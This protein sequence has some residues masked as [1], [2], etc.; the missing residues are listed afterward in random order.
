MADGDVRTFHY[1]RGIAPMMWMLVLISGIELLV[2]HF[3]VSFWSGTAALIL[4]ALTAAIIVWIVLLIRSM[5]RLPVWI[6]EGR[7]VMATGRL[8]RI[9][10]PLANVAGVRGAWTAADLRSSRVLNLALIAYPNVI[11]DLVE[12]IA[13]TRPVSAIA[14]RLDD[15]PAFVAALRALMPEDRAP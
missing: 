2:V 8:K 13:G 5:K 6:G 11:V 14:H 1:H 9:E 10:T 3:L 15:A 4:S 7:L 12:P